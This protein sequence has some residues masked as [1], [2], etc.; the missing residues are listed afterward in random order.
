MANYRRTA[1]GNWSTL[2]QW[3]D[4]STGS[5]VASTV[6]PGATD[7][8]YAN[9][10]NVTFDVNVAVAEIRNTAATNVTAG[11]LF[12]FGA[13]DTVIGNVFAGSAVCVRQQT[14]QV[15]TLIGNVVAGTQ[16][17]INI[18]TGGLNITGNV[19]GGTGFGVYGVAVQGAILNLTGN[20]LSSNTSAGVWN[21]SGTVTINGSAIATGTSAGFLNGNG[22]ATVTTAQAGIGHPGVER[23]GGTVIITNAIYGSTG[24]PPTV[25][26]T[27]FSNTA[28]PTTQVTRQNLTTTALVD[29]STGFPAVGNVRQGVTYASGSLTGTLA[30]PPAAAVSLGVPVDNT[31]G[32]ATLSAQDIF[33]AIANSSDPIAERLRNVST[34]ATTAATVASFDV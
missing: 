30:V 26:L 7:V 8:V 15:K 2:A 32:T 1:T 24:F 16:N 9:N 3:Q 28:N 23:A 22:T 11:G 5:Y 14:A 19:T 31:V 25:G 4:D 33:T 10:F 27:L 18:N 21:N 34:V 13:G 17:G 20:S 29:P 12:D 6:L